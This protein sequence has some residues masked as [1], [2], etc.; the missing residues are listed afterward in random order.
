[1]ATP[2]DTWRASSIRVPQ[3]GTRH[4]QIF[5]PNDALLYPDILSGS[6][7]VKRKPCWVTSDNLSQPAFRCLQSER[8]GVMASHLPRFLT[9][10][11]RV[12]MILPSPQGH[13]DKPKSLP[14]IK[15]GSRTSDTI[16]KGLHAKRKVSYLT[17]KKGNRLILW[18]MANKTI[19]GCVRTPCPDNFCRID[20]ARN[21]PWLKARVPLA[22]TWIPGTRGISRNHAWIWFEKYI[23]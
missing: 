18:A 7:A 20:W 6:L 2:C 11:C 17:Q 10:A 1:M 9:A 5:Y 14:T 13:H 22:S 19:G 4:S 3:G 21:H 23:L 16:K 15:E 12:M 8:T